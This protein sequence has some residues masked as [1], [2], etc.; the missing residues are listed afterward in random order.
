MLA[1]HMRLAVSCCQNAD[2]TNKSDETKGRA[3]SGGCS[4]ACGRGAGRAENRHAEMEAAGAC[5]GI[6]ALRGGL[7]GIQPLFYPPASPARPLEFARPARPSPPFAVLTACPSFV[8]SYSRSSAMAYQY[9]EAAASSSHLR[10]AGT[11]T[12]PYGSGD[13]YYNESSGYI[14]PPG[15]SAAKRR[16]ISPWIKFG[17]PV[18]ICVII[19]AVLGGVLGSRAHN[20]KSS[21]SSAAAASAT[22]AAAASSAASA[23]EAIGVFPTGT[24]SLYMLPLYPSTVRHVREALCARFDS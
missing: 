2:Q 14:A 19:A 13:P 11:P 22:G 16:G 1:L 24:D 15:A 8:I 9:T 17:V 18:L 20:N 3:A 6:G 12:T 4:E 10:P 7:L 5:E 21:A 23:K